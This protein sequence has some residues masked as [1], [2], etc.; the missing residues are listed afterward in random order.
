MLTTELLIGVLSLC[1]TF[2]SLGLAI[3][4]HFANAKK[5]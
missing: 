4:Y 3:G 5:D 1:A 2:F